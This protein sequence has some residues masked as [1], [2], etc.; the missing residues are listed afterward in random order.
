MATFFARRYMRKLEEVS[1]REKVIGLFLIVLMA[2]IVAAYVLQSTADEPGLFEAAATGPQDPADEHQTAIANRLLPGPDDPAWKAVGVGEVTSAEAMAGSADAESGPFA[3]YGVQRIY[4][5]GYESTASPSVRV[6][7]TVCD[8]VTPRQAFGLMKARQPA[9]AG[10]AAI[11]Q[12]G[13]RG[14]ARIGFWKSRYYTELETTASGDE[15]AAAMTTI[16]S[17]VGPAQLDFGGPFAAEKLLPPQGRVPDSLRYVHRSAFGREGLDGVFSVDI[18][19]GVTAWVAATEGAA[20]AKD[21]VARLRDSADAAE[22]RLDGPLAIIP[23]D[24]ST[25]AVFSTG[26]YVC[27]A[28]AADAGAA[29]ATAK[30]S[31][32]M[33]AEPVQTASVVGSVAAADSAGDDADSPFPKVDDRDWQ[34]PKNVSRF[35][36]ETLYQ[37]INGRAGLYLQFHVASMVF[38][39]YTHRSDGD[40]TIDVF[41]YDMGETQNAL[42]IYKNE[43][44]SHVEPLEIG[45]AS[46]RTGG[47]VFFIKG[48]AYVQVLPAGPDEADA[49]ATLAIAAKVGEAIADVQE[50]VWAMNVLPELGRVADSFEYIASDAFGL[51]YLEN[52]FAADYDSPAGRL[53]LFVHRADDATAAAALL[54]KH[55]A[56]FDEYGEI[57]WT[58]PDAARHIVA[59]DSD[60]VIDVVFV[61]GR[62]FGGVTGADDLEAAR[63]AAVRFHD[64]LGAP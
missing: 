52:V 62:Y 63:A 8:A 64:G 7:A 9:D 35:T 59:G 19:G 37:K 12:G 31:H 1:A 27:G 33:A 47:A 21:L 3:A 46:Y 13:W 16:A 10:S 32:A 56:F 44:P 11:G 38:G 41:W 60:G 24:G 39:S 30:S 28:L 61:K 29:I 49:A 6:T 5:R 23:W 54:E 48:S 43:L 15:A 26:Q 20:E 4:R 42:G 17:V 25:L 51:D 57:V 36:P 18:V 58:D 55:L 14:P 50:D 34:A 45:R 22:S 53:K 40:R 2:A